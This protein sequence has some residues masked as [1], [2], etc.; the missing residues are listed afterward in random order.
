MNTLQTL[1]Q[2]FKI[3]SL[4]EKNKKLLTILDPIKDTDP[5][6]KQMK[7]LIEDNLLE[8]NDLLEIYT[9]IMDFGLFLQSQEKESAIKKLDMIKDTIKKIHQKEQE[10]NKNENIDKN[11]DVMLKN[12]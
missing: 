1:T 6:F 2:N 12:T 4:E 8:E 7:I 5:I 9:Q 11:I 3:V 10:E